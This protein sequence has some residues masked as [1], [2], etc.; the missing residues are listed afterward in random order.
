MNPGPVT[1]SPRV[2]DALTLP[3]LCHRDPQYSALQSEVRARLQSVYDA[4]QYEAVLLTGSGTAAV[5]AMLTSLVARDQNVLVLSNGIYGERI[6]AMLEA[7]G[8]SC[9]LMRAAWEEPLD[10]VA[11]DRR[12]QRNP[13][14]RY[15]VT[16]QHE[17]TTGRLNDLAALA[18]VCRSHGVRLLL[19][20][21]SSF[22]G[23]S[24]DLAGWGID[25]CAATANKCLHGAP[26]ISFV[27]V[28]RELLE[29]QRSYASSLY[30]DLHR[31]Y[32][33][34]R[35]GFP[36]F[37]PAVHVMYA[38]REALCELDEAGGWRARNRTYR[39]YADRIRTGL[40]EKGY[41]LLLDEGAYGATLTSFRLPDGQSFD[42]LS[43]HLKQA[44]FVIYAGQQRLYG[45][46]FRIACM[47]HLS[48]DD[49]DE[50]LCAFP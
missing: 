28:R 17:T 30:L 8:K 35:E 5:E 7:H 23:E 29:E 38:L 44:G 25:A 33:A 37:T 36:A 2:R 26:G 46:I 15:V 32:Q 16:V 20:G 27:L 39:R 21:V 12:L 34:Q 31:N 41:S 49:I 14:L 42:E 18:E 13:F 10:L 22:G 43:L 4:T 40:A 1:L 50:L 6:T 47:G 24:L 9:E 19:D 3:D 48:M 45:S 11:I